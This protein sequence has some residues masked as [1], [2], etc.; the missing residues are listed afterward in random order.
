M[1]GPL[2]NLALA[3]LHDLHWHWGEVY[4]IWIGPDEWHAVYLFDQTAGLLSAAT[5]GRLRELIWQDYTE[6]TMK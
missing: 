2:E 1:T 5:S 3:A 4:A 6:R